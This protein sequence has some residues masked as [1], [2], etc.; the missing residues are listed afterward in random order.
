M[1]EEEI[2]HYDPVT[3]STWKPS[4]GESPPVWA[5]ETPE[6]KIYWARARI[7]DSLKIQNNPFYDSGYFYC[8][9]IPLMKTPTIVGSDVVA[10]NK[11]I[12]TRYGKKL[13]EQGQK[14][15]GKIS[16]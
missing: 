2:I 7:L 13:L 5:Y 9:Y 4:S 16:F 15:Y 6:G 11:G 3:Q 10:K 14:Y 8:P 1:F 12:L